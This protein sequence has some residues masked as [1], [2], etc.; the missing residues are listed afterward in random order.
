MGKQVILSVQITFLLH[1]PALSWDWYV[2]LVQNFGQ[3]INRYIMLLGNSFLEFPF[4]S[5]LLST[6]PHHFLTDE[7]FPWISVCRDGKW[8]TG[9]KCLHI[10]FHI[11]WI[12]AHYKKR[13]QINSF[14][15]FIVSYVKLVSWKRKILGSWDWNHNL[16]LKQYK[17][18]CCDR[19]APTTSLLNVTFP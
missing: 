16:C 4:S 18:R 7:W 13:T 17:S 3:S 9:I 15:I 5:A 10:F 12:C 1:P 2:H 11:K 6:I 19:Q 14:N 8:L